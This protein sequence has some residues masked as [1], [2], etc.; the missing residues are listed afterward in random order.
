[1]WDIG[2]R[3]RFFITI[4]CV[5]AIMATS[6]SAIHYHFFKLER[7]RLLE[8]NLEQSSSLLLSNDLTMSRKEFSDLGQEFIDEVIGDDKINMV[9]AI[10]SNNSGNVLYKNDNAYTFELPDS[11]SKDFSK[12]E[13]VEYN[14]YLIK[15]LTQKDKSGS[16]IV[17][18][19]IILNQSLL[20]WQDLNQRI[21]VYVLIILA[22]ITL[23]S[24][25]LTYILFKPVKALA[26]QVNLM[27]EKI[28][29]GEYLEL[30][31]WFHMLKTKTKRPDEFSTLIK[32]LEKLAIKITESQKL[33][34]K[35]S[36]LMAHELKTPMTILRM[37][38][39]KL[40][41]EKKI[42]QTDVT[43]VE[44]ELK[45]LENIIMD[46]L[47]W[48]SVEN[49]SSKPDLH[50][51]NPFKRTQE[52]IDFTQRNFSSMEVKIEDDGNT[53]LRLFCNPIHFDQVINNLLSNAH[54]YGRG[55]ITIVFKNDSL[56]IK[57]NGL[58]YPESVLSNFGKPFNKYKVEGID[59][60]GL[61]LAWVNTIAKKYQW[62]I[63]L[64]ND[65]GAVISL[66][67][68]TI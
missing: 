31:S 56:I 43:E 47:E 4:F 55:A 32:S 30:K 2:L 66:K 35:W 41:V 52:L 18:V 1:M 67:F 3:L 6:V 17:K 63:S 24:F 13:E 45:K 20:R 11:I 49:D 7:I 12:W 37:S 65:S 68:P 23:I 58:G 38:I 50:A 53:D 46:F 22:V 61:G 27:A 19:G 8:Q 5:L 29:S 54:K 25:F 40:L 48:A 15:F 26:D 9:V 59:G 57:D 21:S 33:T 39:D 34:Q 64:S 28:D 10:Y 51:I 14:D 44:A 60:H 16:R 36:A 62:K 42:S